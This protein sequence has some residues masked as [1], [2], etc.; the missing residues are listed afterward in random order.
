MRGKKRIGQLKFREEL[1]RWEMM[2]EDVDFYP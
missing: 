1:R 2:R